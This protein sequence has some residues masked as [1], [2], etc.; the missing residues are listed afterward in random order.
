MD[1]QSKAI[2]TAL[3]AFL[4]E[5]DCA[6]YS[7]EEPVKAL[8]KYFDLQTDWDWIIYVHVKTSEW[9]FSHG[10]IL[11]IDLA[12]LQS[13]INWLKNYTKNVLRFTYNVYA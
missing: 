3:Q 10:Y 2:V 8:E 5:F 12:D 7:I 1:K 13:V 6:F 4:K 11:D 9:E